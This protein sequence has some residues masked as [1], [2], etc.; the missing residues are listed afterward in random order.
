[1]KLTVLPGLIAA[2]LLG[3]TT[4]IDEGGAD[5]ETFGLGIDLLSRY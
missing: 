5:T 3:H 2:S 1:M 4:P